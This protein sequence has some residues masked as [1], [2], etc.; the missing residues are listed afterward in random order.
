MGLFHMGQRGVVVTGQ[1]NAVG[2]AVLHKIGAVR[3]GVLGL[4]R[5]SMLHLAL[6]LF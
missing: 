5:G 6:E 3:L 2:A 1:G 4:Q